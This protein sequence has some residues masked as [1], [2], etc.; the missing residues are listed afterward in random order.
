M[1]QTSR[2]YL[3]ENGVR[4]AWDP[5]RAIPARRLLRPDVVLSELARDTN[6]AGC[7]SSFEL[8]RPFFNIGVANHQR[9]N[10][11]SGACNHD[12]CQAGQHRE[13]GP[14]LTENHRHRSERQVIASADSSGGA[15]RTGKIA[16]HSK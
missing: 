8:V 15:S 11:A 10:R 1:S 3:S 12:R 7:D 13:R 4:A 9:Y 2:V 14:T 5:T 16:G 6:P